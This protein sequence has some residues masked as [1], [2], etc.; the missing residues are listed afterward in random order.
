MKKNLFKLLPLL[1]VGLLA[2]CS[3]YTFNY[4]VPTYPGELPVDSDE[5]D[6]ME[7]GG[8]YSIKIW[9]L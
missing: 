2:G 8:S 6:G 3:A 7:D 9:C 4:I 5:S 1:G